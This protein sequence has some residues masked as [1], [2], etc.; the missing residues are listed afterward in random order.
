MDVVRL[1]IPHDFI[2]DR[3]RLSWRGV[4]FGLV[5]EL[6]DPNAPVA[7]AVDEVAE[8]DD[9]SAPLL[10]LASLATGEPTTALVDRLASEEIECPETEIRETWL[11]IVLAWLYEHRDDFTDP[12]RKVEEVYADFSY[13]ER[14]ASFVRYMPMDG[15]DLG[16]QEANE[17]RLLERWKRFLDES[18]GLSR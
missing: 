3:S 5:N 17:R 2:R 6:L 7:F 12:L 10:E 13:P 9:P 14:I 11:Y 8:V 18:G 16:S 4:Q 1:R 15:P